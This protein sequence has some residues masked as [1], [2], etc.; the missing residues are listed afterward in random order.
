MLDDPT[1]ILDESSQCHLNHIFT[2]GHTIQLQDPASHS[3][4]KLIGAH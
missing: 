2:G 3:L 4:I 1:N